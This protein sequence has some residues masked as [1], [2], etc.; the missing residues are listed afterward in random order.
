MESNPIGYIINEEATVNEVSIKGESGNRCIIEACLI[1]EDVLNRNHRIYEASELDPE[2]TCK[3]TRELIASGNLKGENGHPLS[4]S[5]VR[6]QT[7]DPN[8]TVV[9]YLKLWKNGNKVMAYVTGC[10]NQLGQDFD[11]DIKLGHEKPSFSQRSLGSIVNTPQGAKVRNIKL[12][13]WDRVIYPSHEAAYMQKI[14][15]ESGID[16]IKD[17]NKENKLYVDESYTGMITPIT[18]NKVIDYIKQESGNIKMI[19]E[20]FDKFYDNISL[21][22]N[23]KVQLTDNQGSIMILNLE[24]HIH[25]EIMDYCYKRF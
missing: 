25:N 21:L 13:T 23:G 9:K 6:Q 14:V 8:N 15:S 3:R 17:P 20:S 5:L 16:L 1:D 19:R 18:N 11:N 24:D 12:I 4:K 22:E 10:Q 7:I 2:L